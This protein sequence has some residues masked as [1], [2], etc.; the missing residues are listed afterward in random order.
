MCLPKVEQGLGFR[1]LKDVN[2]ALLAKQGF[3]LQNNTDSLVYKVFKARYFTNGDF[4]IAELGNHPSFAWRSIMVA[5]NLVQHGHRWQVRNGSSIDIRRDKW[6]HQPSSFKLIAPL[7][8][9]AMGA[10]VNLFI[11]PH[12]REWNTS[13]INYLFI[14][15]N[16]SAMLIIPISSRWQR[17]RLVWAY[18]PKR[19]FYIP[20]CLLSGNYHELFSKPR[21]VL[22]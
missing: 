17:D 11:E 13:M 2:L 19:T 4:L 6:T 21:R 5:Q 16:A 3:R 15:T 18:T 8:N 10:Q 22:K 20:Y 1:D 14:P 9:L 7:A 12:S